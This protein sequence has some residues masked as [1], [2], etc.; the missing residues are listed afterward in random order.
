MVDE[1]NLIMSG[2]E[3]DKK[4]GIG[5]KPGLSE[6]LRQHEA[7][8]SSRI[9]EGHPDYK[10]WKSFRGYEAHPRAVHW[11]VSGLASAHMA[12]T[13]QPASTRIIHFSGQTPGLQWLDNLCCAGYPIQ[14]DGHSWPSTEH[15]FQAQKFLN[16]CPEL[17][18]RIRALPSD[19]VESNVEAKRLGRSG[20][21]RPDW[22]EV[23][24]SV[25]RPEVR[26]CWFRV[27]L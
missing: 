24:Y 1:Q 11:E 15:Y 6:A 10:I 27:Y 22:E 21:L 9:F 2:F 20:R 18:E 12:T 23:K 25:M 17:M 14:I 19:S 3:P 8:T 5:S 26:S 16:T 4:L 7:I 13:P